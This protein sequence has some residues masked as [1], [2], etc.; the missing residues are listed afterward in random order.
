MKPVTY[1]CNKEKIE[2]NALEQ[3]EQYAQNQHIEKVCAFTDI[4]FC[5]EKA[6]P[7][8]VAF[9]STDYFYPLVTGK[10]IG[11][12]VMFLK[13]SKADWLKPFNKQ[14]HYRAL[15]LAHTKMTDDGLGGGNHFLSLEEDEDYIYII[16]HTGTRDRGIGLYQH[17][18]GLVEEF[19]LEYGAKVPFVH[20]S[21]IDQKFYEYYNE[22]LQ[23][24]YERRKN[25]CLKTLIFLQNANYIKSDKN[26]ISKNYLSLDFAKT[27]EEGNMYGTKYELKDS[28]HNH[29][30]FEAETGKITH[31][32]GST[33]LTQDAIVVI[34]LSMTRGSLLVKLKP[35]AP[36]A[37]EAL[38]SCAH[39][40]GRK[41]SRFDT[42]KY[43]KSALKEKDRK[44]YKEKFSEMLDR[45]GN[46]SSG[47]IQEFDFAYKDH[48][49]IFDYQS[50][51]KK[52]TETKPIV[53]I[54]YTEI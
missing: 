26:A 47:Y 14:E 20:T 17:C 5:D 2:T 10:D 4:H 29:I 42:L 46:F 1:F 13:V 49:E 12:G 28:I 45:S 52:V 38:Y 11:C 30:R 41:L 51:L 50:Y 35:N 3:V 37:E 15:N 21:F 22:T 36:L 24:G 6:V 23:F 34:P 43:W 40:A 9:S 25:F 7:V 18:I 53:T 39:G 31:R 16:C 8:G 27:E 54:K 19:S 48:S 33:E 44:A 32:K